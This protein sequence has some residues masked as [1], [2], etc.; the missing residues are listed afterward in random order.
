MV[1]RFSASKIKI[2]LFYKL[3]GLQYFVIVSENRLKQYFVDKFS[4]L[5]LLKYFKKNHQIGF[6]ILALYI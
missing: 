1:F 2:N 4:F 3:F 6:Y 5:L